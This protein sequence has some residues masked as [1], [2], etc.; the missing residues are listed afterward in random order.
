MKGPIGAIVGFMLE[1]LSPLIL[2]NGKKIAGHRIYFIERPEGETKEQNEAFMTELFKKTGRLSVALVFPNEAWDAKGEFCLVD[3]LGGGG[4]KEYAVRKE[5]IPSLVD[6]RIAA[7]GRG[8]QLVFDS[9]D[10]WLM[11][12]GSNWISDRPNEFARKF[13]YPKEEK[14]DE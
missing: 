2:L 11:W 8:D 14:N 13:G 3:V 5:T 6:M 1:A 7:V 10:S 4:L 9:I 12:R